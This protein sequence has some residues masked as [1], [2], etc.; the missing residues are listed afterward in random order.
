MVRQDPEGK[1]GMSRMK[2]GMVAVILTVLRPGA[3]G[4]TGRPETPSGTG[5]HLGSERS[6]AHVSQLPKRA[7]RRR[8]GRLPVRQSRQAGQRHGT[9]QPRGCVLQGPRRAERF[10]SGTHVVQ[11]RQRQ[12]AEKGR[13]GGDLLESLMFRA[14]IE[15]AN[16]LAQKCMASS[17]RIC[18]R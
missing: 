4:H 18:R 10:C 14:G 1:H 3:R 17:Y 12:R 6:W 13:Q 5:Q 15:R 16:A 7:E 11:P 9:A 8:Q 2:T